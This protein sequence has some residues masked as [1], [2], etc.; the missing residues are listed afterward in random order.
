MAI[1]AN[2]TWDQYLNDQ[3]TLLV[4]FRDNVNAAEDFANVTTFA[5]LAASTKTAIVNKA[6]AQVPGIK[7]ALDDIVAFLATQ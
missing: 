4:K 2:K 1:P 3:I 6:N 5:S 7:Q